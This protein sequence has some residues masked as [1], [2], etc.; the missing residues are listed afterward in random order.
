MEKE[1]IWTEHAKSDVSQIYEFNLPIIGEKKSFKII[2]SIMAKVEML[3]NPIIG[4]TRYISNLHPEINYQKLIISDY[5]LIYREEGPK[6]F[7]NRVFDSRQDP[8]KVRL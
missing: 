5:L 7:V 8:K 2:D 4:G 3:S 1:V 6:I